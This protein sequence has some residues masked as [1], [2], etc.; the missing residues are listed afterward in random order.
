MDVV[1]VGLL[2]CASRHLVRRKY[3]GSNYHSVAVFLYRAF[4]HKQL[5]IVG[6]ALRV[7]SRRLSRVVF[8]RRVYMLGVDYPNVRRGRCGVRCW[9]SCR[10][11]V[12]VA[13]PSP[14]ALPTR[15]SFLP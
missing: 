1:H 5:E 9:V 13:L 3:N 15:R 8:R 14:L 12:G 7:P 4:C 10:L 6:D 11:G 2:A